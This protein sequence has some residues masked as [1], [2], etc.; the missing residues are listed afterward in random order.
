MIIKVFFNVMLE[1]LIYNEK[2]L[3]LIM[4]NVCKECGM[5]RSKKDLVLLENNSYL[6][7]ACWNK[8]LEKNDR[9]K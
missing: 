4:E 7:F 3:I 2:N 6:C 8:L 5:I 9:E 1:K